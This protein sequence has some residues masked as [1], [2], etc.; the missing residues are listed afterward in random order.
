MKKMKSATAVLL[1]LGAAGCG[2]DRRSQPAAQD[3]SLDRASPVT[4]STTD[5]G[6]EGRLLR[7]RDDCDP[8]DPAWAPTGG[9]LLEEGDVNNAEFGALLNS[10]L[11]LSVVGHPAWTIDPTY[12]KLEGETTVRVTNAGGRGHTFTEVAQFGGG[13]VP[14]LNKGL[15]PA[16]ECASAQTIP[17]GDEAEVKGLAPGIHRFQCCIH[18]WM[19]AL[20]RV[21]TEGEER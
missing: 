21:K 6:K 9:C 12:A 15:L 19:R 18:P 16:P 7:L 10:P 13:R 5:Q 3:L 14:P 20:V 4:S 11:S 8:R 2:S 1:V 17:P